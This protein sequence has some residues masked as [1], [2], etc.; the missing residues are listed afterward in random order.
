MANSIVSF[1]AIED[2]LSVKADGVAYSTIRGA[3]RICGVEVSSLIRSFQSAALKPS[4][5]AEFLISQGFDSDAQ[6]EFAINGIPDQALAL[7]IEYYAF[8]AGRYCT[9]QAKS[10]HRAFASIGIRSLVWKVK[11][12]EQKQEQPK[13]AIELF[14]MQLAIV[15][16]HNARLQE[17][18]LENQRLRLEQQELR[19]NQ[20]AIE[21]TLDQH[22]AEIGRIFEPDGMLISLAGCL[23]LHGKS[24][25]AAKLSAVGRVASTNLAGF[26]I[27]LYGGEG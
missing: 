10:A 15:K 12:Y 6:K 24:A 16:E 1:Q 7:I 8:D 11:R 17:L 23:S 25:T 22:D 27:R 18:E 13:S 5:L 21:Q 26:P 4:K 2:E 14:E 19:A 20:F 3:S 9:A